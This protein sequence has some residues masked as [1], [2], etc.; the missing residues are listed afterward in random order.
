MLV[1]KFGGATTR[2]VRGLENLVAICSRTF[3]EELAAASRRRRTSKQLPGLAVVVSAIGHTTRRLRS[4]AEDAEDGRALFAGGT[5]ERLLERHAQLARSL[6]LSP[7]IYDRTISQFEKITKDVASRVEGVMI[8]RELSPRTLDSFL[9]RGEQFSSTLIA[10]LLEDRGLPVVLVDARKF[11]IT[12]SDFGNAIPDTAEIRK[13]VSEQLLP[14][15]EEGK[16]IL[17]QGFIGG[18]LTGETTTMGSESSDLTATLLGQALDASE[19]VIWKTVP[20][21][22]TAD[23]ELVKTA[24]PIRHLSFEEADEMGRRGVRALFPKV[25]QPLIQ[26]GST[27]TIRVTAPALK[28]LRGTTVSATTGI[29]RSPKPIALALEQ[30]ITTLYIRP[31]KEGSYRN[32]V[33]STSSL[34]MAADTIPSFAFKR[35]YYYWA[36]D[37]EITLCFRRDEKRTLIRALKEKGYEVAEE[38]PLAALSLLVRTRDAAQ[39][40]SNIRERILRALRRFPVRAVFPVES[41]FVI[42]LDEHRSEDALR[43]LHREFFE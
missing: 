2:S 42:L 25:A 15:L 12:N 20:G 36:S 39:D 10:A 41:S 37:T 24:K 4:I 19:I 21:I 18:T 11:I 43:K 8:T 38:K 34:L 9:A 13:K 32:G 28:T 22:Y 33:K 30:N 27:A 26:Q 40:L 16:L 35:A 14:H 23:P 5:L 6:E 29:I 17:T 31:P 7:R 1:Y 3:G